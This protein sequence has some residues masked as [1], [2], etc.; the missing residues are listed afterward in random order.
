MSRRPPSI[1]LVAS[2][3]PAEAAGPRTVATF[4]HLAS[5]GWDAHLVFDG[6]I[7]GRG[8]GAPEL[9]TLASRDRVHLSRV[10]RP[11]GTNRLALPLGVIR[12]LARD[13]A[14]LGSYFRA[15]G[16]PRLAMLRGHDV[17]AALIALRP[18]LVHFDSAS[19]ASKRL[20]VKRLWGHG[21]VVT[22]VPEDVQSNEGDRR[23]RAVWD[24][25]DVL[26]Y[27]DERIWQEAVR[28]G[29]SPLKPRA[30]IPLPLDTAFFDPGPADP[31]EARGDAGQVLRIVSVGPLS[32]RQGYEW[33]L[34]AIRRL[35][36]SGVC[37]EYRI[38]GNG[39]YADALYFA[40]YELGLERSVS[41]AP[42]PGREELREH[43]RWADVYVDSAVVAGALNAIPEAVA[44]GLPIV[45][46]D[47]TALPEGAV[48]GETGFVVPRRDPA[49]LAEPPAELAARPDLRR[50]MGHAT[51][52]WALGHWRLDRY[53]AERERLYRGLLEA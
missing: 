29:C 25:A 24:E 50:E 45:A 31:A 7:A 34:Q 30:L 38:A 44:M 22:L 1:V 37:C 4:L 53:L 11:R 16:W 15:G 13:P 23:Y 36:D 46:S 49:A 42:A 10:H 35:L 3:P 12:G 26:E 6:G 9:A 18:Q 19:S 39:D 43:L 32:W 47:R 5:K 52:Q 33:A 40:R 17:E 48:D 41:F 27:P 8:A 14:R 28:R 2:R 51:R 21:A 20:R